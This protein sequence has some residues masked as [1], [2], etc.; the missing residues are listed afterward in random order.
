MKLVPLSLIKVIPKPNLVIIFS[1]INL[2][3]TSF[4]QDLAGFAYAHLVTYSTIVIMYLDL[5]LCPDFG[6]GPTKYMVQISK[7]KLG[8][9]EIRGI[10]C[11]FKGFP[12]P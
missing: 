3:A 1:Y 10:L 5:I 9:M 8:F 6:N 7:V 12:N 11:N 4:V 2:D